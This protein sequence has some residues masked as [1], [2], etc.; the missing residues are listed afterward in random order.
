MQKK[1]GNGNGNGEAS[2]VDSPFVWKNIR[3]KNRVKELEKNQGKPPKVM[4]PPWDWIGMI[5]SIFIWHQL[6]MFKYIF[7]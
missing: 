3:I 5:V 1:N 2:E 6:I 4:E 7:C